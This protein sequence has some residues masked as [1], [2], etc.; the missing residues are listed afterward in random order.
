MKMEITTEKFVCDIHEE[1]EIGV[2]LGGDF[3]TVARCPRCIQEA[4]DEA[5]EE[6][7]ES[8]YVRCNDHPYVT[9]GISEAIHR[10]KKNI[11]DIYIGQCARCLTDERKKHD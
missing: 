11:Y 8:I 6:F 9:L 10:Q 1:E 5:I 2:D 7:K 4:V 3:P